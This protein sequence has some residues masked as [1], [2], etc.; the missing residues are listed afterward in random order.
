MSPAVLGRWVPNAMLRVGVVRGWEV[1]RLPARPISVRLA[2]GPRGLAASDKRVR[3]PMSPAVL[4]RWA[5]SASA[6][7]VSRAGVEGG[8]PAS[9]ADLGVAR[10]SALAE[11]C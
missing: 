4:G 6:A 5:P 1:V 7:R 10:R 3:R 11:L 8:S 9:Q 2:G